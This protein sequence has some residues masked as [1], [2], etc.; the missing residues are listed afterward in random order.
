MPDKLYQVDPI[1]NKTTVIAENITI[2]DLKVTNKNLYISTTNGLFTLV[3]NKLKKLIPDNINS[4]SVKNNTLIIATNKKIIFIMD[5]GQQ[6]SININNEINAIA[7]ESNKDN[8]FTVSSNGI[9]QKFSITEAKEIDHYYPNSTTDFTRAMIQD[10]SGVLWLLTNQGIVK[11]SKTSI[12]NHKKVFDVTINGIAIAKLNDNLIIGSYGKGLS[13][14]DNQNSELWED[15]NLQLTQEARIITDLLSHGNNLY[16]ASFDGLWRYN[17]VSNKVSRVEFPKNNKLLLNISLKGNLLYLATD[18]NGSYVYDLENKQIIKHIGGQEVEHEES[19]D[20][21]SLKNNTVWIAKTTG[22]EIYDPFSDQITKKNIPSRNKVMSFLEYKNKIF[23]ATKGDGMFVYNLQG[24]LLSHFATTINFIYMTLIN[25]TIWA[26]AEPG[27]YKINPQNNKLT[28]EP[29]TEQFTF[30]SVPVEMNNNIYIGHYGGILE[31]PILSENKFNPKVYISKTQVSGKSHLGNKSI[32]INSANDVITLELASLDYRAGKN[33]QYKYQI[34]NG[35]WNQV[36]GNTLTLTGLASGK[37]NIEIM[38]TNSLGQWSSNKAYTEINVAYPWYWTPHIRLLY[39]ILLICIILVV[40]WLLYLRAKS[41]SHIHQLLTLDLNN[42]GKIALNVS[43]NLNLVMEIIDDD[44]DQAKVILKQSINELNKSEI[45]NA[46]DGL[47]GKSLLTTLPFFCEYVYKKHHVKLK[48]KIEIVESKLSYELQADLYKIIYE[49]ITSAIINSNGRNF[50]VL[51]QEF[52][53]K[54][55]LT[56]T[57]DS[58]SFSNYNN[59]IDFD[60]AMYTIRQIAKKHKA[61]INTFDEQGN[62]SRL[63]ISLPLKSH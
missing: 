21:L 49:A 14:F 6:K 18:N 24:D 52:K 43:R 27:L 32:H 48:N 35:L 41:I 62:G 25:D 33:K 38:A 9:I 3:N 19:I 56:I 42:R 15:I 44:I 50:E 53:E 39:A 22:I 2:D 34:N 23:V 55:W 61:S 28:L 51:I 20:I 59:K 11:L 26:A 47:Y 31:V 45:N 1:N 10:R 12:K 60:I 63:V 30:T 54:L 37:Y 57:D 40:F 36:N 7:V 13:S 16:I 5:D 58:N 17:S 8:I 4:M 46:P 29:N